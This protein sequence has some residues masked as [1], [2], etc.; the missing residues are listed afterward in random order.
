MKIKSPRRREGGR[1]G[2][3]AY[4]STVSGRDALAGKEG[5]EGDDEG[6]GKEGGREGG[7]ERER[8]GRLTFPLFLAA[9]RL[10]VK[11]ARKAITRREEI[12]VRL[13]PRA[14]LLL[15]LMPAD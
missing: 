10:L 8:E 14:F 1:V 11:K 2:G 12:T 13:I 7:R 15:S 5:E 6:E 3:Q 9:T 4:L